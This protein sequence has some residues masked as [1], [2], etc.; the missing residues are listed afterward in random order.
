[1]I[2]T[3]SSFF[4]FV[5]M[6]LGSTGNSYSQSWRDDLSATFDFTYASKYMWHGFD[7]FNDH[8]SFQ[9]SLTIQYQ[10]FYAGVWAAL[11]DSSGFENLKEIDYYIGYDHSFLSEE[12]YAI[13]VSLLYT[14]FDFPNDPSVEAQELAWGISLPQLIPLG[15]SNL[16]PSYM[17]YYNTEGF[18]SNN[19][20][21]NG[22]FHDFGL[23]YSISLPSSPVTQDDQSLDLEWFITYNDGAFGT[24]SGFS[25]T[26]ISVGTTWVWN[27]F[28][29]SPKIAYQWSF[30]DTVNDE[31]DF[32][33]LVSTGVTF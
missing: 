6:L 16:V 12:R 31:D 24:D 26:E 25:H 8:G 21:D 33:A 17:G 4:L 2:K 28:Y 5:I 1:M 11:P 22:W 32:Y 27:S 23:S 30:E 7:I 3:L 9:P 13:D 14:Y 29:L 18:T 19:V 20:T 15:E 10:N